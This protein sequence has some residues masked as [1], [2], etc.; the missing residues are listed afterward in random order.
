[1]YIQFLLST[2]LCAFEQP[3]AVSKIWNLK[4]IS[5]FCKNFI[6]ECFYTLNPWRSSTLTM[7]FLQSS[8]RLFCAFEFEDRNLIVITMRYCR[9]VYV[10]SIMFEKSGF[11]LFLCDYF[12]TGCL[13]TKCHLSTA[14]INVVG[15]LV[16]GPRRYPTGSWFMVHCFSDTWRY[17]GWTL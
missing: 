3:I 12:L 14:H 8:S 13:K 10:S 7:S 5:N 4:V 6:P 15:C 16:S 11:N 17:T 9:M 1:M 2:S